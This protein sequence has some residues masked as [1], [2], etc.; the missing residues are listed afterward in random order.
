MRPTLQFAPRAHARAQPVLLDDLAVKLV[1]LDLFLRQ[2]FVAPRFEIFEATLETA[3]LTTVEPHRDT[4]QIFQKAPVVTDQHERAC[5]ARQFL[6]EPFDG[7]K[8]EMVGRLVEQKYFRLGR[9]RAGERGTARLAAGERR[10]D[11]RAGEPELAEE[12]KSAIGIIGLAQAGF[13]IIERVSEPGGLGSCG[14]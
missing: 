12:I 6:A 4:R 5:E 8:I 7:R 2:S 9:K 10:R 11:F 3:R 13:D 1:A 14:R